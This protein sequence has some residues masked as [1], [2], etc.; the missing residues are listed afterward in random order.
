MELYKLRFKSGPGPRTMRSE[1]ATQR[2]NDWCR[3]THVQVCE[4]EDL[5][6]AMRFLEMCYYASENRRLLPAKEFYNTDLSEA[7]NLE[8]EYNIWIGRREGGGGGGDRQIP[9]MPS[10]CNYPFI[11]TPKVKHR[12]LKEAAADQ[13]RSHEFLTPVRSTPMF[14]HRPNAQPVHYCPYCII[15]V[16]LSTRLL[17]F[18]ALKLL[19][20]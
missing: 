9:S 20:D 1:F 15:K 16:Q 11:M 2:I 7:A 17:L 19:I 14:A 3:S 5:H 8:K 10:L 13:K 6:A 4:S 18:Q 12:I